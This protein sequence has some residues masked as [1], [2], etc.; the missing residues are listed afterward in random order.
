MSAPV[1]HARLDAVTRADAGM[2][3]VRSRDSPRLGVLADHVVGL[4]PCDVHEVVGGSTGREPAVRE[5]SPE[6]V[7]MYVLNS[8][9][10]SPAPTMS[11]IPESV[12]RAVLCP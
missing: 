1:R 4:P 8:R 6:P 2:C 12:M 10:L 3:I 7:R 11:R 5:R 9:L